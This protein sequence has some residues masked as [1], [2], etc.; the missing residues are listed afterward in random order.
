MFLS[1][2]SRHDQVAW[3]ERNH[4][5]F[6]SQ[7]AKGQWVK[8]PVALQLIDRILSHGQCNIHND[9]CK[10]IWSMLFILSIIMESM[11]GIKYFQWD[12]VMYHQDTP[13]GLMVEVGLMDLMKEMIKSRFNHIVHFNQVSRE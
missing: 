4:N 8:G 12:N 11:N 6:K 9:T 10:Y 7:N 13:L 2:K 5:N 3:I 1:Q